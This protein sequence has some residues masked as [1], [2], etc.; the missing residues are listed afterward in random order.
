MNVKKVTSFSEEGLD[1]KEAG[2]WG[3]ANGRKVSNCECRWL[4]SRV[5][6]DV[7]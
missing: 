1:V 7:V 3:A 5:G 6:S 2:Q 4:W